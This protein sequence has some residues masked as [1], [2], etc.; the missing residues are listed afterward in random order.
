M[1]KHTRFIADFNGELG[2]VIAFIFEKKTER[3]IFFPFLKL[4]PCDGLDK[5]LQIGQGH[6]TLAY[7][8]IKNLD[9][10]CTKIGTDR[11]GRGNF[12]FLNFEYAE[13]PFPDF[14]AQGTSLLRNTGAH[15]AT[16]FCLAL[17]VFTTPAIQ[18]WVPDCGF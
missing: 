10:C 14:F 3:R 8:F 9:V 1:N 16:E 12:V 5:S 17:T 13:F 15:P 2:F 7:A 4:R 6:F 11:F 18:A